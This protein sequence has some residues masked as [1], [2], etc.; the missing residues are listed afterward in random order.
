M[1]ISAGKLTADS[2]QR[3]IKAHLGGS[4][5]QTGHEHEITMD[6]DRI[7]GW[8]LI[9]DFGEGF[10]LF[11]FHLDLFVLYKLDFRDQQEKMLR[12]F[13]VMNGN[14]IHAVAG[15]LRYRLS[16]DTG[17]IIATQNDD[18]QEL[19]FPVQ[20]GLDIIVVQIDFKRFATDLKNELDNL[21][22]RLKNML[23]NESDE[24]NFL[25]HNNL[26]YD[27]QDTFHAI[28]TDENQGLTRRF[29]QE[30]KALELLCLQTKQLQV[31]YTE[32]YDRNLLRKAD[33][34]YIKMGREYIRKNFHQ[35]ITLS[36]LAR[37]TGTN[38]TKLKVGFKKLYGKTFTEIVRDER[39]LKARH[40]IEE[41]NSSIK[42]ISLMCGYES[43]SMFSKR[44]KERYGLSPGQAVR[45]KY[46]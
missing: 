28:S 40:L 18:V 22:P 21:P 10:I 14:L 19:I 17:S 11:H 34:R 33:V 12:Y 31:E 15:S 43:T 37:N 3:H 7:R 24:E 42:E 1:N 26:P 27:I 16:V 45:L 32:G 46:V 9:R 44:F 8:V 36:E 41:G 35:P 23:N 2:L 4:H 25:Y 39:L 29:F 5:V 6:N 38:E 20:N 30:S 13:F